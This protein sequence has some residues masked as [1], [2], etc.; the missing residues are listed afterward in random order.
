MDF[1]LRARVKLPNH[2]PSSTTPSGAA[3]GGKCQVAAARYFSAIRVFCPDPLFAKE[4]RRLMVSSQMSWCSWTWEAVFP[5]APSLSETRSKSTWTCCSPIPFF[6]LA[7]DRVVCTRT[8]SQVVRV[9]MYDNYGYE[10]ER[11]Q[12]CIRVFDPSPR[13]PLSIVTTEDACYG[14]AQM[15]LSLCLASKREVDATLVGRGLRTCL[16]YGSAWNCRSRAPSRHGGTKSLGVE[17]Q[18]DTSS[19][20]LE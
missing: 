13:L 18:R 19:I 12:L 6:R 5:S 15:H 3:F 8:C 14:I 4:T 7:C 10:D 17:H 9:P 1:A 2:S 20:C 11:R 16:L